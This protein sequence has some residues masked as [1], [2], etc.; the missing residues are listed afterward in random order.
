MSIVTGAALNPARFFKGTSMPVAQGSSFDLSVGGIYD[1]SG[2][3]VTGPFV[4]KPGA[5]VQVVSAEVFNLPDNVTG[6]VTY[7]TSL[8]RE[9]IWALTVG[10][11]DPGWDGP[12]GTTLL[13]FSRVDHTIHRGTR[14]LRVTLFEHPSVTQTRSAPPLDSYLKGIQALASS[15]FPATFLDSEKIAADA[16]GAVM[17]KMRN[18]GLAWF[19]ATAILFGAIQVMAPP[20]SRAFD[21]LFPPAAVD[22]LKTEISTLRAQIAELEARDQASTSATVTEPASSGRASVLTSQ[23]TGTGNRAAD[24]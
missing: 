5:M 7:K 2:N 18:I 16:A 3:E 19:G 10:I 1:A 8:T 17:D 15:R 9:G 11:V 20:L 4:L 24:E 22:E 12:I 23:Q 6:H 13:N 14:F 21:G